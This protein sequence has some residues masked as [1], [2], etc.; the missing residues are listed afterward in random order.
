MFK[1]SV[2]YFRFY[3][4]S[5]VALWYLRNS[6]LPVAATLFVIAI[7]S[8]SFYFASSLAFAATVNNFDPVHATPEEEH[9]IEKLINQTKPIP[10]SRQQKTTQKVF[11]IRQIEVKSFHQQSITDEIP[12]LMYHK[13]PANFESQLQ[14]IASRGYMPIT[15][16]QASRILRGISS[17]P[18]KPVVITFD[19]GFS[20]QLIAFE[21]LKKY[22]MPAT[23]YVMPGGEL[24]GW[25]VGA[26]RHNHSCG[27]SYLNWE[28]I[29]ML[30]KS[31][32]IEIGSHTIDHAD[33]TSLD[34]NTK[35]DQI[36]SAKRKIEQ[37]I[38]QEVVSFAYPYG[39]FNAE[40]ISIVREAGYTSA[41]STIPGINQ[42]T[43]T[44]F[45]LRR[46]RN[47]FDLN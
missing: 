35:R 22:Q 43:G 20:D 3:V 4:Y 25:C 18:P 47:A 38:E 33:L 21:L 8:L 44:L 29:R 15:M 23:F 11:N 14:Y 37:Q 46:I 12:I 13:T 16:R 40:S 19:D 42:S 1:G 7:A 27:D 26:E 9:Q 45:E 24:S 17:S 28:E 39:A 31:N 10:K 41:V 30:A 36:L 2:L 6:S 34:G 32:L 5:Q